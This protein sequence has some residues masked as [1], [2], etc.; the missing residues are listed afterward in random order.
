MLLAL[1]VNRVCIRPSTLLKCA[2]SLLLCTLLQ[3]TALRAAVVQPGEKSTD[4]LRYAQE[5]ASLSDIAGFPAIGDLSG[6]SRARFRTETEVPAEEQTAF[7][8]TWRTTSPQESIT[9]PTGGGP[10]ITDYDVQIDWG[11]GTV[12]QYAGDDPD[13]MHVY[14]NAG[15]Y[16]VS[17]TGTFPH[18]YMNDGRGSD[19]NADKL[20]SI[21]QWGTIQWESMRSAFS[22]AD[23]LDI[24][25]T[26]VPDLTNVTDMSAMFQ[27]SGVTVSGDISGWDVSSV[28][29][30]RAMFNVADSF[31]HDIG[32]WDV[33]NVTDMEGMFGAARLFNQDISGWD[34]SNVTDMSSMFGGAE[35]FNQDISGWDVSSVTDMSIMFRYVTGG[36]FNQDLSTWD[37]SNVTDMGG[38]FAGATAFDQD[39]SNWDVSNVESFEYG[40]ISTFTG[41]LQ[42]VALSPANYDALLIGWEQLDLPDGLIFDAG[43]SQYTSAAEAAR[44]AIINDDGWT[45]SD[46]GQQSPSEPFVTTWRTTSP[47]ESITIPTGGGPY[48]FQI[49]WGDGTVEQYA[50]DD[51]DPMHVYA[52]AG[53]YTVSITGTFSSIL[54]EAGR[55]GNGDAENAAKLRSI[56]QWGTIQWRSMNSA[57]SGATTMVYNATDTPDLTGVR[58]ISN[59]FS[60]APRFNGAIGN[61][62]VSNVTQ[63][64]AVF[65]G[66]ESFNQDLSSWDVSG[67]VE[68]S[69]MF[70]DALSFDQ[71]ISA[72]DVSSVKFVTGMFWNA[73]SF[74]QPIG[75]WNVSRVESMNG[76]FVNATEFNQDLGEWDVSSVTGRLGMSGFLLGAGLSAANYDALLNGW[77]R[78]DLQDGVTLDAG[79]STYTIFSEAARQ[80]IIDD[81]GWSIIDGGPAA[82][83]STSTATVNGPGPIT[84]GTTGVSANFASG[85]S[86]SGAVRIARYDGAPA[87]TDGIPENN[88]ISTYRI[89][90]QAAAG[91]SV[92]PNT[93]LR[94]DGNVFPGITNAADVTVYSRTG[95]EPFSGLDTRPESSDII[96][97][98]DGFSEFVFASTTNPLPVELASLRASW[99]KTQALLEW[100]TASEVDN[101]GF[102]VERRDESGRWTRIGHVAGAGTTSRPQAYRFRDASIPYAADN[103]TY[104]LRQLDLDGTATLS[105]EITLDR[106]AVAQLELLGPFP[107]PARSQATVQFALPARTS[108]GKAI[109]RLY[110]LLGRRV[111]QVDLPVTAGRHERQINVSD[112]ASGTYLLR[113][114]AGGEVQMKRLSIVR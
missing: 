21:E 19:P 29:T 80:S 28:T 36:Q 89:I 86:G 6:D 4:G 72:W 79:S 46:G 107:N 56:E 71:D 104:R 84:F 112:L 49:D 26:D 32:S 98:V 96:A 9:I 27:V 78:L 55:F 66:A 24:T 35:N 90:I 97:T 30:M 58:E 88:N 61:W 3:G 60:D 108:G 87:S 44:Q 57:F 81:E 100:D 105:D 85:T 51:P 47:Q 68:M 48:A 2:L 101:A 110:D 67:V 16:T 113:L 12:E 74:N 42:G 40:Q 111:R 70:K 103:L 77:S 39:L 95:N 94:F 33:F 83:T 1:P 102:D 10:N 45:I 62:D 52:E 53:T 25:A 8:T 76:M 34:V 18:F 20:L 11:D 43:S 93:E 69:E 7:V 92:G 41:F 63:M 99:E 73:R 14:A 64:F 59:M 13:P 109:L 5:G 50:G 65:R 114:E 17:I 38:M 106:T 31:N 54:L 75:S 15:T 37:V 23:N 91:L 82:A 22:G